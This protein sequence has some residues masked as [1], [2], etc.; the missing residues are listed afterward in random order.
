MKILNRKFAAL[1]TLVITA[2][3]AFAIGITQL[4]YNNKVALADVELP[5]NIVF[6]N[7]EDCIYDSSASIINGGFEYAHALYAADLSYLSND[8]ICINNSETGQARIN[9]VFKSPKDTFYIGVY[10]RAYQ[11]GDT[12]SGNV[13][14]YNQY[15]GNISIFTTAASQRKFHRGAV[16]FYLNG[17]ENSVVTFR[18][19]YQAGYEYNFKDNCTSTGNH[20]YYYCAH[21][22]T[23]GSVDFFNQANQN[24]TT[25]YSAATLLSDLQTRVPGATALYENNDELLISFGTYHVGTEH[26]YYYFKVVNETKG[27]TA[28]ELL[29]EKDY[30]LSEQGRFVIEI[31]GKYSPKTVL[32]CVISGVNKPLFANYNYT[33]EADLP[34]SYVGESV[35]NVP[36][37]SN[38]SHIAGNQQVLKLGSNDINVNYDQG[39][40][41]G[42][43]DPVRARV[44][45]NVVA[46]TVVIKDAAGAVINSYSDQQKTFTLP[47]LSRAKAFIAYK[48][49][50]G[51]LYKQGEALTLD[52]DKTVTLIEADMSVLEKIDVR[53]TNANDYYGGLRFTAKILT[54]D[55]TALAAEGVTVKTVI[56]PADE[57]DSG[58]AVDII[59]S[60]ENDDYTYAYFTITNFNYY[61][62][63]REFAGRVLALVPYASGNDYAACAAVS[64]SVYDLTMDLYEENRI[65]V[66]TGGQALYNGVAA[67][68]LNKYIYGVIDVTY[69][70]S[71]GL[72]FSYSDTLENP[73]FSLV[74]VE[75]GSLEGDVY[76]ATLKVNVLEGANGF[77][78]D[79]EFAAPV[80]VRQSG[81]SGYKVAVVSDRSF[82][83][84][85]LTLAVSVKIA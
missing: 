23:D 37:S 6:K 5:N 76:T 28:Y 15:D 2:I 82:E 63:N 68:I 39:E 83:N 47:V 10:T 55:L 1:I 56:A 27:Y 8:D 34:S 53:L 3:G 22:G 44:T 80:I 33:A 9:T 49:A 81:S 42:N 52:G 85:V 26:T 36:L 12:Y 64:G 54:D 65:A 57:T 46:N 50:D 72:Q 77:I 40:Y 71:G 38:Y 35:T 58:S 16:G 69:T 13:C 14:N 41:Y 43:T 48:D 51:T 73:W 20:T 18:L 11:A 59:D 29:A 75:D 31:Y 84:G 61:N 24:D 21:L 7:I 45:V 4:G 67:E 32:K 17:A 70:V 25:V 62:F 79:S 66:L 78:T 74:A 30:Y 19:L 60:F